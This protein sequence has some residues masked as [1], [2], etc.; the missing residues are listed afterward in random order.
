MLS[1]YWH[2][3]ND[4]DPALL[5]L[6]KQVLAVLQTHLHPRLESVL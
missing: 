6:R 1:M 4:R 3:R 2:L 5:W